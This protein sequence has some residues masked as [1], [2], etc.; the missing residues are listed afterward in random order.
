VRRRVC[1]AG[2]LHFWGLLLLRSMLAREHTTCAIPCLLSCDVPPMCRSRVVAGR[3]VVHRA[4][5]CIRRRI[6]CIDIH[7]LPF[8]AA[9]YARAPEREH[10]SCATYI[11]LH[12][13]TGS[14]SPFGN[15]TGGARRAGARGRRVR[16]VRVRVC[17]RCAGLTTHNRQQPAAGHPFNCN[18][19]TC[20]AHRPGRVALPASQPPDHEY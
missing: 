2:T 3:H 9:F 19:S 6:L 8:T 10:T 18:Y 17:G 15:G 4:Y 5:M 13:T 11:S 20:N 14:R 7:F 16:A 1:D 12:H